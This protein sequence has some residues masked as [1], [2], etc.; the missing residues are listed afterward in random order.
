MNDTGASQRT[1]PGEHESQENA[2]KLDQ[3]DAADRNAYFALT[4]G[5][6]L[7]CQ[8]ERKVLEWLP[9]IAYSHR[10]SIAAILG[11]DELNA[12]QNNTA[13][14]PPQKI[15]KIFE[16]VFSLRFPQYDELLKQWKRLERKTFAGMRNVSVAASPYFEK[17]R[18]EL[19]ILVSDP[20]E[21]CITLGKMAAIPESTW[22]SLIDPA[23]LPGS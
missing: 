2:L 7:S 15:E 11:S 3:W 12:I 23:N 4:D 22:A 14:N 1:T 19:R 21:A 13:L 10:Q 5:F 9:E 17:N 20:R 16:Y 18:L 8:T 6:R